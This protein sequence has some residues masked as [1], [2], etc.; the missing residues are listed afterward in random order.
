MADLTLNNFIS[1]RRWVRERGGNK[2]CT[3]DLIDLICQL[4]DKDNDKDENNRKFDELNSK[5][6]NIATAFEVTRTQ[7]T[8]KLLAIENTNLH[9]V[10]KSLKK[11]INN[12][13]QYLRIDNMEVVDLPEPDYDNTD[14]SNVLQVINSLDHDYGDRFT[15][16]G[17]SICHV[18]PS[19]RRYFHP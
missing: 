2:L 15:S 13:Q 7:A 16:N 11:E 10:V 8:N 3:E 9:D 1:S 18:V 12:I 4:P 5:I 17:I 14:E 6:L 19:Q